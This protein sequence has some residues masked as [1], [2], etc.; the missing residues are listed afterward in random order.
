MRAAILFALL[1]AACPTK[2]ATK[3]AETRVPEATI[4]VGAGKTHAHTA[5]LAT[6]E[7]LSVTYDAS[8]L[9]LWSIKRGEQTYEQGEGTAGTITFVAPVAGEYV[10]TFQNDNSAGVKLT[11]R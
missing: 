10:V 4:V 2:T 8:D 3:P 7:T 1:C 11:L 9:L 6:G 5:A